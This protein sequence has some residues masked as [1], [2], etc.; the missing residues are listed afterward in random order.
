MYDRARD[1]KEVYNNMVEQIA[2]PL[3]NKGEKIKITYYPSMVV[4]NGNG[5]TTRVK[6]DVID[7]TDGINL[8]SLIPVDAKVKDIT[9]T[10]GMSIYVDIES[11]EKLSS[12]Y[13]TSEKA[14]INKIVKVVK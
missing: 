10:D 13:Y 14:F 12:V 5:I 3:N 8:G 9:L 4:D 2:K 1:F 11:G 6:I 7:V